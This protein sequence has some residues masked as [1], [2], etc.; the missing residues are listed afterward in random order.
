MLKLLLAV[1][2]S[3]IK[4]YFWLLVCKVPHLLTSITYLLDKLRS[5]SSNVISIV[6]N[7]DQKKDVLS[8]GMVQKL[9]D[10]ILG[11]FLLLLPK[12]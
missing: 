5:Q 11:L 9:S 1:L 8:Q 12:A 4:N 7:P 6:L 2:F 3:F 10:P